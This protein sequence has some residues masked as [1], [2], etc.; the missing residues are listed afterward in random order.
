MATDTHRRGFTLVETMVVVVMLG[1]LLAIA[2]PNLATSNRRRR[3]E[4]AAEDLSTCL[5]LARQ[6]TVATRIPFRVVLDPDGGR[7]WTERA[8]NDSTWVQ[9]P[10]EEHA[11]PIGVAWAPSAGGDTGN[12]DIEFEGRGTVQTEDAPVEVVFTNAQEDTFTVSLVRTG[13]VT[14]RSHAL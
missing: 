5:Q 13:R 3:A 8:E 2:I 12:T 10:E 7:F 11:L 14:V 9:D 1:M 6:R 4:A